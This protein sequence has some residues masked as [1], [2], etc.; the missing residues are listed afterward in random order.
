M[1][2]CWP[3]IAGGSSALHQHWAN[4]SC[5]LRHWHS[6]AAVSANTGQ[7]HNVVSMFGQ[8]RGLLVNIET[9]LGEC[10]WANVF[11]DVLEQSIISVGPAS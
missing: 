11:A 8:R 6:N 10:H 1:E 7:S 9:A 3:N 4:V 5:Y 2:Q